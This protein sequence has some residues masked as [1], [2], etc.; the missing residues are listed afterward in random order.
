[1]LTI[2]DG[3]IRDRDSQRSGCDNRSQYLTIYPRVDYQQDVGEARRRHHQDSR[4]IFIAS[5]QPF[6]D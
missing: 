2:L 4:G 3:R 6:V 5:Q 1:M